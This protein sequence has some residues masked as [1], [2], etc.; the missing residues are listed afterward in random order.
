MAFRRRRRPGPEAAERL[1]DAV[2][3]GAAAARQAHGDVREPVGDRAD[4]PVT[5]PVA[6][7]VA[8]SVAD[9]VA[10]PLADPVGGSFGDPVA[11]LLA[12]AAAPARPGELQ[13][14]DAAVA[15]FRAVRDARAT[16]GPA[17]T[18]RTSEIPDTPA[19]AS[20]RPPGRRR[21]LTAGA[22]GWLAALVATLTAGVALAAEI[23][24]LRPAGPPRSTPSVDAGPNGGRTTAPPTTAPAPT[25]A[26]HRTAP[27]ATGPGP[28]GRALPPQA[29]V[30][31]CRAFVKGGHG[32]GPAARRPASAALV[33]AAG[34]R[35]EVEDYC[36]RLLAADPKRG[37]APDKPRDK[38]GPGSPPG[39]PADRHPGANGSR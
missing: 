11:E 23:P 26:P 9:R 37:G 14:E 16:A 19:G 15:A 4:D 36:R 12:V 3:A 17:A 34:G 6:A 27:P 24:A 38:G 30:A 13:G 18:A 10:G 1:L 7:S 25:P 32:S 29:L 39:R 2:A 20:T 31:Q 5:D 28:S 35:A 21:R 8:A 33:R 22:F